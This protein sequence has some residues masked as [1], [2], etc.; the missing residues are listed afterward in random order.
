MLRERAKQRGHARSG[1][2][3]VAIARALTMLILD[4]PTLG[5]ARV[6]LSKPLTLHDTTDITVLL[7]EQVRDRDSL[8]C[9]RFQRDRTYAVRLGRRRRALGLR[10]ERRLTFEYA[11][12]SRPG[13]VDRAPDTFRCGGHIDMPYPQFR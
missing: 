3:M 10:N 1:G 2:E 6:I 13:L 11:G 7:G 4:A 12:Q 5:L 9:L 8:P